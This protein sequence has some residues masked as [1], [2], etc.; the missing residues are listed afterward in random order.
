MRPLSSGS[1]LNPPAEPLDLATCEK[2]M[3]LNPVVTM[4]GSSSPS[5][6]VATRSMDGGQSDDGQCDDTPQGFSAGIARAA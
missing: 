1:L 6:P 4:R 3:L 2:R 5:H